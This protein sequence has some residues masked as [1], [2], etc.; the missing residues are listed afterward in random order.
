MS[1][2]RITYH[3]YPENDIIVEM[4]AKNEDEA[5]EFAKAC[6]KDAFSVEKHI[7]YKVMKYNIKTNDMVDYGGGFSADDVKAITRG[8]KQTE[9][10]KRSGIIWYQRKNSNTLYRVEEQ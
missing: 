3:M 10:F 4:R 1:N 7:T 6:R 9:V 8:Y 2:Y 5:I